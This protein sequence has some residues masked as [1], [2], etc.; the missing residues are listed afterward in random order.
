MK[1]I[2]FSRDNY[3]FVFT[4][5][6]YKRISNFSDDN[7][8]DTIWS[9]RLREILYVKK[10][11]ALCDYLHCIVEPNAWVTFKYE[12]KN[13]TQSMSEHR[14]LERRSERRSFFRERKVSAAQFFKKERKVSAV[15]KNWWARAQNA[16]FFS[17][18]F[19]SSLPVKH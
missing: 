11:V 19:D 15:H 17:A 7:D 12:E 13:I 5:Y 10:V 9:E 6:R 14:S 2:T 8:A 16:L 3:Q 4:R 1:R 18:L